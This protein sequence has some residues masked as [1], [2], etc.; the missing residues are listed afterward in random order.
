MIRTTTRVCAAAILA[1]LAIQPVTAGPGHD[2][3]TDPVATG[4]VMPAA[5]RFEAATEVYELV[6]RVEDDGLRLWLDRFAT[7]EPVTAATL[8]ITIGPRRIDAVAAT[9]DGTYQVALPEAAS[10]G[11][12]PV[13]IKIDGDGAPALLA[14]Q[15]VIDAAHADHAAGGLLDGLPGG[16][17]VWI[18]GGAVALLLAGGGLLLFRRRRAAAAAATLATVLVAAAAATA[19][20]SAQAG[21][22]HD[23]GSEAG[24]PAMASGDQAI[25]LPDGVIAAPKAM[26]RLIG[27]RTIVITDSG[28]TGAAITLIGQVIADPNASGVVQAQVAGRVSGRLP[29]LGQAVVQGQALATVT[30][31]FDAAGTAG[32]VEA[33]GQVAQ[34]LA[35]ARQRAA[36]LAAGGASEVD[37]E[38]AAARALAA[39]GATAEARAGLAA[40]RQRLERLQRLDGVVPLRD[41]EAARADVLGIEARIAAQQAE[42]DARVRALQARRAALV[43]EAGAEARALSARQSA[44]RAARSPRETLRAPVSGVVSAVNVTQGQVVAPGETLFSIIQPGALLVQAQAPD[45]VSARLGSRASGRT[46]DGRTFD[47]ARLG[48]GL[49][50]IDGAAPVRFQILSDIGLRVGEPVSVF[51]RSPL[52][53]DGLAVPREAVVRGPNGQA[54]VF[55]K[56]SAERV[57]P[58]PVTILDLDAGRVLVTAGLSPGQRI[59]TTG[60]GLLAQVR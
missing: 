30:P 8:T 1:A 31:G 25:R 22:G 56:D 5:P 6:G 36:R 37:A 24:A 43:G 4:A 2:H 38:L 50:L 48:A 33:Q 16:G 20:D 12:Y 18:A 52:P 17:A 19:P 39:G 11:T 45:A 51:V 49:A 34:D 28:D 53:V 21:P 3:G 44:L 35:L 26:Q 41:I 9:P 55:V 46:G 57:S 10:A 29:A 23:H 32:I 27:L 40:A 7:N 15:L 60:A 59:V 42:A 14:A 58:V 47:L 54:L 13:L